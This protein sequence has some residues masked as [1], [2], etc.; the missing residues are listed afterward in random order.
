MKGHAMR[1]MF[2]LIELLVVIAIIAIL[3]SMLLPALNQ[4]R[5]RAKTVSCTGNMKQL[6]TA[7][8][9]YAD[10]YDGFIVP[11]NVDNGRLPWMHN[12]AKNA[13]LGAS[14]V[15]SC[16]SLADDPDYDFYYLNEGWVTDNPFTEKWPLGY[17]LN[18]F[19]NTSFADWSQRPTKLSQWKR[20][21]SALL[22]F[23]NGKTLSGDD[24]IV[25]AWWNISTC[26]GGGASIQQMLTYFH[27]GRRM[28]ILLMDGHVSSAND[29]EI[30]NIDYYWDRT[31]E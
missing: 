20:P 11:W 14:R 21:S 6:G 12:L 25:A 26:S 15:L 23:D 3:A 16:P 29:E 30:G 4:A 28:N 9:F 19:L 17:K 27:H 5:D 18:M 13:G 1:K 2:T 31:Q 8:I 10:S 22:N 24:K 7:H